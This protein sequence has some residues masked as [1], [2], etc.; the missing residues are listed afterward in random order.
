MKLFEH[1]FK[2]TRNTIDTETSN[3]SKYKEKKI[4]MLTDEMNRIEGAI[5]NISDQALFKK[6]QQRRAD[7]NEEK[8]NLELEISDAR[9]SQYE[10]E[11][12]YNDAKTVIS[13]PLAIRDL[14]DVEIKQLLI[15]VC[16]NNKIYY[17]KKE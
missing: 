3:S 2:E 7:L 14:Q 10:F 8:A 6:K 11:K 13:N 16:F 5:D 9:F 4:Q 12:V 15:R 17:T 1:N